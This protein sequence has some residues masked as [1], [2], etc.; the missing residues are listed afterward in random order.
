MGAAPFPGRSASAH[1][2]LRAPN[3]LDK[4][5]QKLY[6]LK[7][8]VMKRTPQDSDDYSRHFPDVAAADSVLRLA[9]A[10]K[11][12]MQENPNSFD[13]ADAFID[14]AAA[15]PAA[16]AAASLS[17]QVRTASRSRTLRSSHSAL[18]PAHTGVRWC[19]TEARHCR[20]CQES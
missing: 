13:F 11:E 9:R 10:A 1:I 17:I 12:N 19:A 5:Q 7:A 2:L 3:R 6:R 15:C 4:S 20:G 16:V 14:A 8:R 18:R